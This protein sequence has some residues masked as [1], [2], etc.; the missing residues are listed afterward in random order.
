MKPIGPLARHQ[1][2]ALRGHSL[3]IYDMDQLLTMLTI[4]KARQLRFRGGRPPVMVSED[5]EHS[6]Q[7]PPIP[8]EDVVRLLRSMASSREMRDLRE[9][10]AVQ[11]IYTTQGRSPFLVRARMEDENVVFDVS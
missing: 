1:R 9:C 6:L 5:E 2:A 4:E 3:R 11:F 7:G 8:S 10:G